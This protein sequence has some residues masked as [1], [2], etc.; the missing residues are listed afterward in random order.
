[1]AKI[2]VSWQQLEI[3]FQVP[4][5]ATQ[6]VANIWQKIA[7]VPLIILSAAYSGFMDDKHPCKICSGCKSRSC[8]AVDAYMAGLDRRF[9][10]E[11]ERVS[12]L[13]GEHNI[14]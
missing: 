1:M 11:V 9:E 4:Q 7:A 6:D 2:I 13:R 10:G 14:A 5:N 8:L 12:S 3:S